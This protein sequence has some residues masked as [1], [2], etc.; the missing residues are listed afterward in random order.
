MT[1]TAHGTLALACALGLGL[2]LAGA[3]TAQGAARAADPGGGASW[4]V[5]VTS[6][7][8]GKTCGQLGQGPPGRLYRETGGGQRARISVQLKSCAQ[9]YDLSGG[10]VVRNFV[11]STKAENLRLTRVVAGGVAPRADRVVVT[12]GGRS[13]TIRPD[14]DGAWIAVFGANVA[15]FTP[16]ITFVGANGEG[17][18][19]IDYSKG[20]DPRSRRVAVSGF[21]ELVGRPLAVE[22]WTMKSGARCLGVGDLVDGRVGS[23]D[24][25]L[26]ALAPNAIGDGGT[27]Q[28]ASVQGTDQPA[29]FSERVVVR[30]KGA[31]ANTVLG[32]GY[33]YVPSGTRAVEMTVAGSTADAIVDTPSGVFLAAFGRPAG[34]SPEPL[35][36][37]VFRLT[38][39]DGRVVTKP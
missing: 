1:R 13:K 39:G 30:P 20:A 26:G 22:A 18:Q 12:V 7:K 29:Y 36:R 15:K 33:G 28:P 10:L 8:N 25:Y 37:A 17:R 16:R 4:T 2:G 3:S 38:L 21:G 5:K 27:C 6:D 14:G 11:G 9:T 24:D 19:V 35:G 23:Y 34:S 32:V 31:K